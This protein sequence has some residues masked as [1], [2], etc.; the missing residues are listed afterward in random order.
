VCHR[1]GDDNDDE[2]NDYRHDY[3]LDYDHICRYNY[4]TVMTTSLVRENKAV[5]TAHSAPGA[6]SY[7]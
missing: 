7:F 4:Y 2:Y 6:A 3:R 5:G 1:G